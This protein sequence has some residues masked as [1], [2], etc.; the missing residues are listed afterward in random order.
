M[1]DHILAP[2]SREPLEPSHRSRHALPVPL[3]PLL[4]REQEVRVAC[5]LLRRP[6]V[7]LLT[8]TGTGGVGKTRLAFQVATEAQD[9]FG[10]GV[11]FIPL[12]P[13]SDPE[14][15]ISTIAHTFRLDETGAYS[16]LER[17]TIYLSS[18]HLLLLLDNFEQ[19]ISAAPVLAD[20]L[21]ACP[22]LKMLVTSR[23]VL[24]VRGEHEFVVQPLAV[25]DLKQST[26]SETLSQYA[27]VALFTQ[28]AQAVKPDFQV[29][30]TNAS[31]IAAICARLDGLP[32][33]LELAAARLKHLSPQ[34]LLA[35]L[36]HRLQ[37]LTRGPRDVSERQQT[38][39]NTLAWS[40][41]LLSAEE[42]QLFRCLA[43]FVD[44]CTWQ[45]AEAVYSAA[46][47]REGDILEGLA[48]LV[49]KS[50]LRQEEQAGGEVRF[51]MLQVLREFGL[52][53]LD[54]AGES[55]V[56][57]EA[58]AV[59]YL[60]LAEQGGPALQ[61]AE[62]VRWLHRL[63][64][65]QENMRVALTWLLER[66]D[67]Q[68]GGEQAEFALRLGEALVPFWES[69]RYLRE[70][71]R[72]LERALTTSAVVAAPVRARALL[73]AAWL[74][75]FLD[76][77][78]RGEALC[79][80][81]LALCQEAGDTA[82]EADAFFLLGC[83]AFER[84]AYATGRT[85]LEQATALFQELGD[86]RG[87]ADCLA[88]LARIFKAQGD[89]ARARLLLEESL[90]LFR[91]LGDRGRTSQVLS[92]LAAVCFESQGD[93]ALAVTLTEQGLALAREQ[94]DVGKIAHT[95][96]FQ[97]EFI[98]AQGQTARART[99]LKEGAAL[100][101]E[102]LAR[103][104]QAEYVAALGETMHLLGDLEQARALYLE[105]LTHY[106]EGG[107]TRDA[108]LRMWQLAAVLA[109]QGEPE[110]A[111]RLWGTVEAWREA[112]GTPLF[113]VYRSAYEQ[114][115]DAAR[116]QLGEQAFTAAWTE[117]R[118]MTPEQLLVSL[119]EPV[120]AGS[121]PAVK[122]PPPAIYPN[123]LTERE[124]EVLRL[125]AQGLTNAQIAGQLVISIH[126][127]NNHMKSILSKLGVTSR[128]AA[129]RFAF[130]HHLV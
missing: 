43:V 67:R 88:E 106:C 5:T 114:A 53:A 2:P 48:A 121:T 18:K 41:D 72:F 116:T 101:K 58:H 51:G 16:P 102:I 73:A 123:D 99:V 120:P 45:A 100:Y 22:Q 89:Y 7:R 84:C 4:G 70:G 129:T 33:A 94:G 93:L 127:A 62:Q 14:L 81:G 111:I 11:S 107:V 113:P 23:E 97:G 60:R 85:R 24:R 3:T 95:L 34:A 112:T 54:D 65:E 80:Q 55:E 124:V 82:G 118:A 76:D 52:Q 125:V 59:Y 79:E 66:A 25:P 32:L 86:S 91:T 110:R 42:Q 56:T 31:T 83:I 92:W 50:L 126:T 10:D 13:I 30:D 49:D 29:T 87:R 117:G 109:G 20:L 69:R 44:G 38:L 104:R 63:K 17:L 64:Q 36:E 39:R 78:E 68:P 19:I 27:A 74:A 8:L 21:E 9:D 128:T 12:A 28:R 105:S 57:S 115:V 35:R 98:L 40:Y 77:L 103:T 130:E 75:F 47:A 119:A 96:M 108:I 1:Q 15:L 37:V 122:P 71:Q 26:E 6:E 90:T 61:G 46:G